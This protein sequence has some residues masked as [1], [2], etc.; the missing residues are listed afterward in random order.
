[1][2]DDFCIHSSVDGHL[3]CFQ[4]LAII[5]RTSVNIVEQV[6]VCPS[7]I[8]LDIKV[9]KGGILIMTLIY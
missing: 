9:T 4:L 2:C 5:T 3:V 7:V 8:Q 1:M 6:P